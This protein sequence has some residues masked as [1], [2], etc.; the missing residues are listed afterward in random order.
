MSEITTG[1]WVEAYLR[2]A[3]EVNGREM[4]ER[5]DATRKAITASRKLDRGS[6]HNAERREMSAALVALTGIA[7]NASKWH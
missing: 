7:E 2:A 1:Q 6:E 3:Y 4:P 5:I